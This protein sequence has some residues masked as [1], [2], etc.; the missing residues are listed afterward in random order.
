[1][2]GNAGDEPFFDYM[3]VQYLLLQR[4]VHRLQWWAFYNTRKCN[5]KEKLGF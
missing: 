5:Y 3:L 2:L 1:M 4:R